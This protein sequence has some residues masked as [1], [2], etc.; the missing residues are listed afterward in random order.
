MGPSPLVIP[1]Y[2]RPCDAAPPR[3]SGGHLFPGDF[4]DDVAGA[5]VAARSGTRPASSASSVSANCHGGLQMMRPVPLNVP[6]ASRSRMVSSARSSRRMPLFA[7]ADAQAI[8]GEEVLDRIP[9]GVDAGRPA[10][11]GVAEGGGET[12]ELAARLVGR[13]DEDEAAPLLRRDEGAER[14]PAVEGD[15]AHLVVPGKHG[16]KGGG[17]L[18]MKLDGGQPVLRAQ[19]MAGDPRRARIAGERAVGVGGADGVEVGRDEPGEG[20]RQVGCPTA[21]RCRPAIR[22]C[23]TPPRRRGRRGRRRRGCR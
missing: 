11:V 10:A 19:E 23:A 18:R 20:G 21:G 13:V 17:V 2:P 14:Q 6:P 16:G 12:V 15:D 7:S 5:G 9:Q 1:G 3:S 4:V 22:R 8:D